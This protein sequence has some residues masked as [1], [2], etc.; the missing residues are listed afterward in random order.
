L[1]LLWI[2]VNERTNTICAATEGRVEDVLT[3]QSITCDLALWRA[4]A[5]T[6]L[7]RNT[8]AVGEI[9]DERWITCRS[10]RWTFTDTIGLIQN[11]LIGTV[12]LTLAHIALGIVGKL[13][14]AVATGALGSIGIIGV[15]RNI[16]R[17]SVERLALGVE[18]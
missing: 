11:K 3:F 12:D 2:T 13:T 4:L 15:K 5:V 7:A 18:F 8:L 1:F 17:D 14:N 6:C 16:K 9:R 10:S